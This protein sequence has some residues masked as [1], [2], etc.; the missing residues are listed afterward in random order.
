MLILADTDGFGIDLHQFCQRIL[1]TSCDGCGAALAHVEIRKLFGGQ[2]AGG[3]NTGTGLIDDDVLQGSGTFTDELGNHSFGFPGGGTVPHGDEIY[4]IT[5]HET[6]KC[7]FGFLHPVLRCRRIDHH[8]VQDFA[9]GIHNSQLA[10]GTEGGIPA[11]DRFSLH[12][13]LH[14]KLCEVGA[15]NS[16]GT[17]FRSLCQAIAKLCLDGRRDQTFVSVGYGFL[18]IG[19]TDRI[20]PCLHLV[21]QV[22]KNIFHRSSDPHGED[23]FFFTAVYG[24]DPMSGDLFQR[25]GIII[26]IGIDRLRIRILLLRFG[27]KKTA[28]VRHGTD[29]LSVVGIIGD[30]FRK[31]VFCHGQRGCGVRNL[32]FRI[33]EFLRFLHRVSAAKTQCV[34]QRRQSFLSGDHSTGTAFGLIRAVQILQCHHGLGLV[35]LPA[36]FF[37]QFSLLFNGGQDGGFAFLQIAE[38][39][40]TLVKGTKD[41]VVES[42]GRFL[43]VTG[44]EGNGVSFID[45]PDHGLCLPSLDVQFFRNNIDNIH[46][47]DYIIQDSGNE[48]FPNGERWD[49]FL[50]FSSNIR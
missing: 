34:G 20:A 9:G 40:E 30:L 48:D 45:Q 4:L 7:F 22:G 24:E 26:V 19:R 36:Q 21:R 31:N 2:F 49:Y 6:A 33:Y 17:V 1:Q 14:Q 35:N 11:E 47:A 43:A 41:F 5:V 15:E 12:R 13:R 37:R 3:I 29:R 8:G 46:G 50:Y 18:Q 25:F 27:S 38:V 32:F 44:N 10:S 23:L 28:A 16:D 39:T 42:A